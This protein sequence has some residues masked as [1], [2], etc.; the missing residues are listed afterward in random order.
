MIKILKR[1]LNL[2]FKKTL[3][4]DDIQIFA[5]VD[6]GTLNLDSSEIGVEGIIEVSQIHPGSIKLYKHIK[7][8]NKIIY[9]SDYKKNKM[10]K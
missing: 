6:D 10:R 7:D 8:N 2:F 4:K 1:I 3:N 5:T 9:M